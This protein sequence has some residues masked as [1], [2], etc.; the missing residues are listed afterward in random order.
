MRVRHAHPGPAL[1]AV[2]GF[3]PELLGGLLAATH[4]FVPELGDADGDLTP[5]QETPR[6]RL[7]DLALAGAGN[8]G[9]SR[10]RFDPLQA[11]NQLAEIV[12]HLDGLSET[13]SMLADRRSRELLM[14]VLRFRVLGP[15]HVR[16]PLSRRELWER[17][18]AVEQDRLL[19]RAVLRSPHGNYLDLLETPGRSGPVRLV[20]SAL[21]IVEFFDLAQYR[22]VRDGVAIGPEPGDSV[23]DGGGGWGET[24]LFFADAVGPSGRV[25]CFEF[26]AENVAL[27]ERNLTENPDLS[28]RIQLVRHPVWSHSGARLHFN[29]AGPLTAVTEAG[30]T[31]QAESLS[32]DDLARRGGGPIDFIKLDVEGAEMRALRGAAQTLEQD[33]PRLAIAVY[34]SIRDFVE[35]PRL[36]H[37]L[38]YELYL[39]HASVGLAETILFA[40]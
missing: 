9:L 31:E 40:R 21:Q 6:T 33:R 25:L 15:G 1:A 3:A 11:G 39:D 16:L 36:L 5:W 10:R 27:I 35:I 14:T 38:G 32:I 17:Y 29:A 30:G 19:A 18:A 37:D 20:G 34:H 28:G 26:V 2:E 12:E 7:R 22:F 23:V 24:A 8:V 4:D 13:F